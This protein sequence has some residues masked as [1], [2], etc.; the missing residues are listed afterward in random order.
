M[1]DDL[2]DA[3]PGALLLILIVLVLAAKACDKPVGEENAEMSDGTASAQV[4][5][6]ACGGTGQDDTPPGK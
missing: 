1:N 4:T 5:C 6:S 2:D 3:S